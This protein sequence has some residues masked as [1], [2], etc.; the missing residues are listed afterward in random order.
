MKL[1]SKYIRIIGICSGFVIPESV[2]M[3]PLIPPSASGMPTRVIVN[4][5][6][7]ILSIGFE[8]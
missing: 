3:A 5:L 7:R 1:T 8:I 6:I 2:I 4:R